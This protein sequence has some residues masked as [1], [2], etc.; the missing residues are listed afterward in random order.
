MDKDTTADTRRVLDCTLMA[1]REPLNSMLWEETSVHTG[2]SWARMVL[3]FCRV[4]MSH[5]FTKS[6]AAGHERR[7]W[8]RR[9]LFLKKW[10]CG[11]Y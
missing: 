6:R 4:W 10:R 5:T 8:N 9:G 7:E 11:G 1:F 3:T 2:L